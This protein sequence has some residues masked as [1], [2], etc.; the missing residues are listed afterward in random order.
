MTK[1]KWIIIQA[2]FFILSY[3]SF[4]QKVVVSEYY[5]ITGIPNGE[6]T[7]LLVVQDNIDIVGFTLRDNSGST[8]VP[9]Q[10][11]GGIRFKNHPLWRNLRSGTIIVINHRYSAS[12]RVDVDKRDGYIEIDAENETYFEKRCF[13]CV[14]GIDWNQKALNIA[15]G[16]DILEIIDNNDNHVHALAHMPNASGSW[17]NLPPPKI[18]YNGKIPQG[19][20]SV[21]VCPGRNITSYNKG[22]DVLNE[23]VVQSLDYVTKGKPNNRSSAIDVNQLFWRNL[24]EPEWNSPNLNARIFRDKVL[25]LWNSIN[26]PNPNDSVNGYLIIRIPSEELSQI[27]TPVDGRIYNVG[28]KLGSA[29]VVGIVNFSQTTSF[30]DKFAI[31]CDTSYT[32]RIYAFRYRADDF[33]E[34]SRAV[35]ARGRSYNEHVVGETNVFKQLPPTPIL[36]IK[37]NKNRFCK[38]DSTIIFISNGE[39]LRDMKIEWFVDDKVIPNENNI[40]IKAKTG[41]TYKVKVTDSLNCPSWSERINIDVLAFPQVNLMVNSVVVNNDTSF[42]VCKDDTVILV[43]HG[44]SNYK[45]FKNGKLVQEGNRSTFNVVETGSYRLEATNNLCTTKT[46]VVTVKFLDQRAEFNYDTLNFYAAKDVPYV[47]TTVIY[48]NLSADTIFVSS[49]SFEGSGF[50]LITPKV[51]FVVLPYGDVNLVTRFHPTMS[52]VFVSKLILRKECGVSDTLFLSGVK[53]FGDLGSSTDVLDF[54]IIPLCYDYGIDTTL[55]IYNRSLELVE[56]RNFEIYAPFVVLS[57]SFPTSIFPQDSLDITIRFAVNQEG[58]FQVPLNIVYR[59]N[60]I[61]DTLKLLVKGDVDYPKYEIRKDFNEPLVFGEC[62]SSM[63]T[64]FTIVNNSK[65]RLEYVFDN[66]ENTVQLSS[67]S[68]VLEPYSIASIPVTIRPIKTGIA[69]S[70]LFC[71]VSPCGIRDSVEFLVDKKGVLISFPEMTIDFGDIFVCNIDSIRARKVSVSID[72]DTLGLVRI[73]SIRVEGSFSSNT[74]AGAKLKNG[75]EIEVSFTPDSSGYYEGEITFLLEPCLDEYKFE[76]KGRYVKGNYKLSSKILDFDFV[77]IGLFETKKVVVENTS[78]Q[79]IY[80]VGISD[81]LSPFELVASKT[82]P[83][84]LKPNESINLIFKFIPIQVGDFMQTIYIDF[85]SPC[86]VMD[87]IELFGK[88]IEPQPNIIT[89]A[90]PSIESKPMKILQ[91]PIY[92][93]VS[94]EK[95]IRL[96]RLEFDINFNFSLFD[97]YKIDL[98][99][100]FD[101]VDTI[102]TLGK[103]SF[104]LDFDTN[105]FVRSGVIGYLVGRVMLGDEKSTPLTF[106]NVEALG[107]GEIRV[108]QRNGKITL[109]SICALDLRLISTETLPN[110]T[111]KKFENDGISFEVSSSKGWNKLHIKVINLL[112]QIVYSDTRNIRSASIDELT[113]PDSELPDGFYIFVFEFISE[114]NYYLPQT[115]KA[116][117]AKGTFLVLSSTTTTH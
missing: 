34:D 33:G 31:P 32:Y 49:Y 72:G 11:T 40:L 52:G 68:V 71:Y 2:L 59:I 30:V 19:G 64:S 107:K 92:L 28:D 66:Q 9:V 108:E 111:F 25:L 18:S 93:E 84:M 94:E 58:R 95:R 55:R 63:D 102:R 50:E 41:G 104:R 101:N 115:L 36:S 39:L 35:Y 69:V 3:F 90:L 109:D 74:S 103:V 82:F 86:F 53:K 48:Y 46:P 21:Q 106:A 20:V 8:G 67:K 96:F 112:G 114:N 116:L 98:N 23:E 51:P 7:E 85:G 12:Q 15:Q 88:G 105:S 56:L 24:R 70:K 89:L 80:I 99:Y 81:V 14:V 6:W 61:F 87:S 73:R 37:E 76:L 4:S 45:W 44:W 54:G 91:I 83:I 57:P 113:I 27:Q 22:F 75:E 47:D 38:G 60:N 65:F 13:S 79:I 10:W 77:E 100:N 16:S 62:V 5:N 1:F 42:V 78:N 43:A 110:V 97:F 26:D 17:L 117:I 29:T